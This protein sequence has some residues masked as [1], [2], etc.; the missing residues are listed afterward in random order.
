[1]CGFKNE[2]YFISQQTT[3]YQIA[4]YIYNIYNENLLK[5]RGQIVI[6]CIA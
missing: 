6:D 2:Q 5:F 4:F 3:V 1:M